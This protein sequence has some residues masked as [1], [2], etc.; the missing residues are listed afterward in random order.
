[1][2][3]K[4]FD[5]EF[6]SQRAAFWTNK[7]EL[8][9]SIVKQLEQDLKDIPSLIEFHQAVV[10]MCEEKKNDENNKEKQ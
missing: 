3:E 6:V 9:E 8:S 7:K 4:D 5:F 2:D 1:M 10:E